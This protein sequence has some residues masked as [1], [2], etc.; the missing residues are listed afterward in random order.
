MKSL[1]LQQKTDAFLPV[2]DI[3][4]Q[5]VYAK[6]QLWKLNQ[7]QIY[8]RVTTVSDL[9]SGSGHYI[10]PHSVSAEIPTNPLASFTSLKWPDQGTPLAT[11]WTMWRKAIKE[12]FCINH[13]YRPCNTLRDWISVDRLGILFPL[14]RV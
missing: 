7:C 10:L 4:M 9:A 5:Q 2:M 1:R 11:A 8:L 12:C 6:Y 3:F 13:H 14:T